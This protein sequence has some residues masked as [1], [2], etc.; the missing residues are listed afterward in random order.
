MPNAGVPWLEV[1]VRTRLPKRDYPL[2]WQ[3]KAV[4]PFVLHPTQ[5]DAQVSSIAAPEVGSM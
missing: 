1:D 2:G 4:L 5:L 3:A